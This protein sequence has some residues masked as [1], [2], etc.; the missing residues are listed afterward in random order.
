MEVVATDRPGL[1]SRIAVAMAG[2][3]IRLQSAKIATYGERAED[4][5]FMTNRD[6]QPLDSDLRE[7]CRSKV[8]TALSGD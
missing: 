1:L 5:F 2:C 8:I 4:V 3:G 7:Q 6:N